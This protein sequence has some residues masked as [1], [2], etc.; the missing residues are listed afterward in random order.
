MDRLKALWLIPVLASVVALA[1]LVYTLANLSRLNIGL[2]HPRVMV[3]L[4]IFLIFL[5]LGLYL[6]W[7]HIRQQP[8]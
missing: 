4:G 5:A 2:F 1:F 6:R 3:E 7:L 8:G